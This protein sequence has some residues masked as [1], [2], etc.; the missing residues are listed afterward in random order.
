MADPNAILY[1]AVDG[2]GTPLGYT[3]F[4]RD[5][6][7]ATI[8]LS[9]D[10]RHRGQGLGRTL[11]FL[12]CEHLFAETDVSR[13]DAYVKPDNEASLKL[14]SSVGFMHDGR[15]SICGQTAEHFVHTRL[16]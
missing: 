16:V 3:R 5:R 1:T 14:F 9:L 15:E 12:A 11:L 7:L 10:K 4:Q 8:S 13:I 6:D 2:A